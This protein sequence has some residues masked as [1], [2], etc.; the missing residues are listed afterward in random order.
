[1]LECAA[2]LDTDDEDFVFTV[3][4]DTNASS[5][6]KAH[7]TRSSPDVKHAVKQKEQQQQQ[8]EQQASPARHETQQ[9]KA[10]FSPASPVT[11]EFPDVDVRPA[12]AAFDALCSKLGT[13]TDATTTVTATMGSGATAHDDVCD[14]NSDPHLVQVT[15]SY[16]L[17]ARAP[18]PEPSPAGLKASSSGVWSNGE[19]HA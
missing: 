9:N 6:S 17:D 4:S 8:H 18:L 1:M 13:C 11:E 14:E 15:P 12:D 5:L 7:R 10:Q 19:E 3:D 2:A 16:V